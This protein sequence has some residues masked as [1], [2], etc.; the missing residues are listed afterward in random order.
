MLNAI[1]CVI[2]V[3]QLALGISAANQDLNAMRLRQMNAANESKAADYNAFYKQFFPMTYTIAHSQRLVV[4]N[5]Q[6]FLSCYL[7]YSMYFILLNQ[8]LHNGVVAVDALLAAAGFL[9]A[10]LAA[11]SCSSAAVSVCCPDVSL[12]FLNVVIKSY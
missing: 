7:I 11:V 12:N 8:D 5:E 3:L 1:C 2:G 10:I 9:V 6:H 4:S